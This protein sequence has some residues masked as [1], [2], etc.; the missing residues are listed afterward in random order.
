MPFGYGH[1]RLGYGSD[2]D[3]RLGYGG[4]DMDIHALDRRGCM[5]ALHSA[6]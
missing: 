4:S 1:P 5:Q 3:I 6:E 2:M